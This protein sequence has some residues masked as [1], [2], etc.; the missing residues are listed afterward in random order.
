MYCEAITILLLAMSKAAIKKS[1]TMLRQGIENKYHNEFSAQSSP[2]E[3]DLQSISQNA[4]HDE[5]E[6]TILHSLNPSQRKAVLTFDRPLLIL[7]GAGTGKTNTITKKIA[8]IIEQNMARAEQILAVTFT[9]KAANEMKQRVMSLASSG[10]FVNIGTF[11]S[12]CLKMLRVNWALAGLKEGFSI[13]DGQDQKEMMKEICKDLAICN[14]T[15]PIKNLLGLISKAKESE[16]RS[17]KG[18]SFVP[19]MF[20]MLPLDE[21]YAKY[22]KR[23]DEMN[24]IDFDDILIKTI[25]ML[26]ANPEVMK[27]Y[28]NRYKFIMVDEYQ[29][30]NKTQYKLIK[31]IAGANPNLCV[32]GDDDQSIYSWRGAD[33]SNILSFSK[34]Y[35]N[36][37]VIKLEQNYR[38]TQNILEVADFV[39]QNNTERLGKKLLANKTDNPPVLVRQYLD[40]RNEVVFV[41]NQIQNLARDGVEYSKIAVL[42]RSSAL[43]RFLE[44][45]FVRKNIPYKIVGGLRFYERREIKDLLSYLRLLDNP[46]DAISFKRAIQNP[47]RGLGDASVLKITNYASVMELSL[48]DVLNTFTENEDELFAGGNKKAS[49]ELKLG[50]KLIE[51]LEQF[52]S[53]YLQWKM[54]I[55]AQNIRLDAILEQIVSD[56]AYN[57]FL[58]GESDDSKDY[59]QKQDNIREFLRLLSSFSSLS[60]FLEHISLAVDTENGQ[61]TQQEAVSIMTVHAS[62][63]LEFEAVFMPF[64]EDGVFPNQRTIDEAKTE[65]GLEEERR[66]CYVAITRAIRHLFITHSK[67][68]FF[69]G[70]LVPANRSRFVDEICSHSS[71]AYETFEQE[72]SAIYAPKRVDSESSEYGF[73]ASRRPKNSGYTPSTKRAVS[74]K[75]DLNKK[76]DI[77]QIVSHKLFGSGKIIKIDGIFAEVAFENGDIKMIRKDFLA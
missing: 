68:R 72:F 18:E 62:K 49:N 51:G 46:F 29:D 10:H 69:G 59:E 40:E 27:G 57:E 6:S 24:C 31:Y 70:A 66:L 9:N 58:R 2:E 37:A 12:V 34:D 32:V 76:L 16:T 60:E 3:M 54:M 19:Q 1:Q 63:G 30:T 50:P 43:S 48:V 55:E 73:G 35:K 56:T 65:K 23:L 28:Q 71:T 5:Y 21:I 67:N 8:Y 61:D 75:T 52:Y 77:D 7:A 64:M 4:E 11:H 13:I 38:S 53:Q 22:I 33:I 17:L 44:E 39:I 47:K 36:A 14:K 41:V 74:L 20:A 25:A 26:E 15:Y 45:S 42:L